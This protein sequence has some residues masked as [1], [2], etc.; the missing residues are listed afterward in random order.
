MGHGII[1]GAY[2][3]VAMYTNIARTLIYHVLLW[4][5]MIFLFS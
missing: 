4:T 3:N 5:I 1:M 2:H